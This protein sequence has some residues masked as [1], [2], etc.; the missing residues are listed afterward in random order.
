MVLLPQLLSSISCFQRKM[1]R[2]QVI[3]QGQEGLRNSNT[4]PPIL[5]LPPPPRDSIQDWLKHSISQPAL[6]EAWGLGRGESNVVTLI[7]LA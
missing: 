1:E 7:A 4:R 3:L 6:A 2:A 5:H